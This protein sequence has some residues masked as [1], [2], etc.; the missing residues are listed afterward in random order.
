M[1]MHNGMAWTAPATK[2]KLLPLLW[3][4]KELSK[5]P[6]NKEAEQISYRKKEK[7]V[8]GVLKK[9]FDITETIVD[10]I[11]EKRPKLVRL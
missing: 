7:R 2:M 10:S 3:A 4:S 5:I 1:R 8:M 9:N 6:G 11:L